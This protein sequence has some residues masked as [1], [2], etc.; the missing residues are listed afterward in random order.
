MVAVLLEYID[1]FTTFM[2]IMLGTYYSVDIMCNEILCVILQITHSFFK[3]MHVIN[4]CNTDFSLFIST[5][6][7]SNFISNISPY[8]ILGCV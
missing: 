5:W 7:R 6:R 3:R 1:L 4:D 2:K 8:I